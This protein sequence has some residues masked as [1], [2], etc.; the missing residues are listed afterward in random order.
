MAADGGTTS[1]FL[2]RLLGN[3]VGFG[4]TKPRLV[5]WLMVLLGCAG[6]GVTVSDLKLKTSRSDLLAPSEEWTEYK[7]AFGGESDLVVVVRTQ[8]AN[9]PLI[10]SVMDDLGD[11]LEREPEYFSSV[12]F[13]IDQTA[14]RRKALQ[15]LTDAELRSAIRRVDRF[16]PVLQHQQWDLLKIEV[17]ARQLES[18]I[19]QATA[20]QTS[21]ERS[22]GFAARLA[23]SLDGFLEINDDDIRLN[24]HSFQSPWEDIV[25]TDVEH[26][27]QDQDLAYLMNG[28]RSV[29]MLHVQPVVDGT[30]L[31]ENSRSV[32]R[33]REHLA[34]V[35]TDY[36]T[37]APDLTLSLTGIPVLEHDE[38]RRSGRDMVNAALIAFLGVGL[39]LT[40]GLRGMRHPM[41]V[42]VMLINALAI[43][44]GIATLAV[45]HLSILSICFAAI[46]IGLGVDF[47]I[48]FVS[49]YL[50][51]RQELYELPEALVLVGESIGPGIFTSAAT[52]ALA[53]GSATLTGY[54]GLAELGM[55][56]AIGI[57]ICALQAFT[58]LPALIALSDEHIDVDELPVPYSGNMWRKT[59]SRFPLVA[60][61]LSLV[62]IVAVAWNAVNYN[63][64]EVTFNV[65][66]DGNLL[67]MQDE[68][69][70]SVQAEKILAGSDESL[71]YAVALAD[72]REE[73]DEL[74]RRLAELPT[75]GRVT[76]LSSQIPDPPSSAQKQLITELRGRLNQLPKSVPTFDASKPPV[77]GAALERLY[78]SLK[79]SSNLKA[80]EAAVTFDR[81]LNNLADL[82]TAQQASV[83]D[84]YQ[85]LMVSALLREF[86]EVQQAT[87]L[88]PITLQD[89]PDAWRERYL[90]TQDEGQVWLIKVYP[91]DDVWD[92]AALTSFVTDL[93]TV[94]PN[95]TGVPVQQYEASVRT[96]ECYGIIALY[97]LAA[98]AMFLLFD[99]LR[100]GQ[101]LMTIVPPL[102]VVGFVGYTS[103]QRNGSFDPH[104]L[105]G[106]Y[107][108]MV[109]FI[110][111]VFD[112]RNLRDTLLALVPP[113]GGGL[114][115]LGLM[116]VMQID[117][118][119][120]NLVVVPLVLGIGVDDGIHMVHDYR[121][122]LMAGNRDYT[123]SADTINGVL[124]TSLTSVVGFGALMISAHNG[125]Q[126]VGI[127]LALGVACCLAVALLLVP[128]LLVL[129]AKHQPASMEPV[130]II[131]RRPKKEKAENGDAESTEESATEQQ[132]ERKLSRKERRRQAAA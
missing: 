129:V 46:M 113:F 37:V 82:S 117:F 76:E 33:L 45:G 73:T 21:S 27:A 119:P 13:K 1:G 8:Y 115:L 69:L 35:E 77:V 87:S 34:Q 118:N 92:Q 100:P 64:G 11:R 107:L 126:S 14:L 24:R 12:L 94:A 74:S 2:A 130:V 57:G 42:M 105:V 53:F 28:K 116:A 19:R 86:G 95:V 51:L 17:L 66:Y 131:K 20:A 44:F 80:H 10:Q 62:G 26:S 99:F 85:D 15:Y 40:F 79:S 52:T 7:Q 43:T 90:R 127:V 23:S 106:I 48:H 39:L 31:D 65:Q 132:A 18:Q 102:L 68:N 6:V 47:G 78:K 128:A 61:G 58:F 96:G 59:I 63:D 88:A 104:M 71:L 84:A 101:K 25:S 123:P 38:L 30:G 9:T 124:F 125:L 55:I 121:R 3:V 111:M 93:R 49:R 22:S 70:S 67:Q 41:L 36:K 91:K 60:I 114:M 32:E 16:A 112:F 50:H 54:P 75:V 109:A 29:G 120:V 122:Q 56:S 89:L 108:A 103:V 4:A 110:A 83:M 72:S 97:S 81:F 5:L 98:I